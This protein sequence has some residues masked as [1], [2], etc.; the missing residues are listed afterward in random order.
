MVAITVQGLQP[1]LKAAV[2]MHGCTTLEEVRQKATLAEKASQAVVTEQLNVATILS[3]IYKN[4]NY[5]D[6]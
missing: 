2:F 3:L 5:F 6:V 4:F 1:Y